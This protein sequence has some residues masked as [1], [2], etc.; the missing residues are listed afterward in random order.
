[1]AADSA[2]R[3]ILIVDDDRALR[4]VLG[5][6]LKA[7]GQS[8]LQCLP[9]RYRR[10]LARL[11]RARSYLLVLDNPEQAIDERSFVD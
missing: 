10:C 1:M 4:H 7:A 6:L 8:D 2:S 5:E 9:L 3:R 11:Y